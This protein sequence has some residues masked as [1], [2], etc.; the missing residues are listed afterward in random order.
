MPGNYGPPRPPQPQSDYSN[1][2]TPGYL[3]GHAAKII[4]DLKKVARLY[5]GR[6][7]RIYDNGSGDRCATCTDDI[8]GEI[9]LTNCPVCNGTGKSSRNY[10]GE[11]WNLI[12]FGPKYGAPT[13]FGNTE[14]PGGARDS[15]TVLGAPLLFDQYLIVIVDTKE[16]FKII[17]VE[18]QIVAMQGVVI[19]QIASCAK[20]SEGS[21][22]YSVVNW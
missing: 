18:P 17:D 16:V 4:H 22:E 20:M 6:L 14:N 9:V 3:N 19:T 13:E 12:D 15:I 10:I 5:N 2:R 7:V 1:I 11:Y 8:T 21:A